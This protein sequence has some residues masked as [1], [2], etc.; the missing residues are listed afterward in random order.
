MDDPVTIQSGLTYER[1]A[2]LEH[3]KKSG[4]LDPITRFF[5]D[6]FV[7]HLTSIKRAH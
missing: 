2:L 5:F 7:Y 3:L 4:H 1:S 6:L